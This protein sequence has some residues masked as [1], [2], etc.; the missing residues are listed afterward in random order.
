LTKVSS[1][2]SP[3]ATTSIVWAL[4]A[5]LV[6]AFAV[7]FVQRV[8]SPDMVAVA[9]S[10]GGDDPYYFF[11]VARN[12][13]QGHGITVDGT[14]WTTG[15][16]PLWAAICAMAF[17]V[18]PDRAAFA[19]IYLVSIALWLASAWLFVRIVRRAS[20][21]PLSPAIA[22][23]LVVL[24]LGETQFT[25]GYFN[26]METG[27]A[28]TCVLA[29]L[30]AFQDYLALEPRLVSLRRVLGLGVLTGLTMLARND[31]LFLCGALLAATLF[32]G[33]RR[34]PVRDVAIIVTVAS[35]M[36]APWLAY[37]QWA[38]GNPMPQSGIATS[39]GVRGYI[40]LAAVAHKIVLSIEPL[41]FL[42]MRTLADDHLAVATVPA[43][44][45]AAFLTLCWRRARPVLVPPSGW[46]LLSLAA[47][48]LCLLLFYP[49]VSA[50]GQFFERYFT[51]LKLLVFLLLALLIVRGLGRI[52]GQPVTG[53]LI[54]AVAA[55]TVGSNLYWIARDYGRPWRSHLGPEAYEIVRSPYATGTS[56]IG[57]A[58]SGRL[59]FLYPTRIV[60][61]DGKMNVEA[62][63]ALLAGRLDSYIQSANLDYIMLHDEDV[64]YFDKT[65]PAW[66]KNWRQRG[67][68]GEFEVFEKTP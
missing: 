57:M 48:T 66:R 56:R 20:R 6:G 58:E 54:V 37:C 47:A 3:S 1:G 19:I 53:V 22:A 44:A 62:L 41:G 60:N 23:L 26:G 51:P 25:R 12:I 50:A 30:A 11:T 27:L 16:Q 2:V 15:F 13:A 43:C 8:T 31:T 14:H 46:I 65:I 32:F 36:V 18:P 52:E 28:L 55:A 24:F 39:I 67:M 7:D 63:H 61:L 9:F 35:A 29:L 40:S 42:K 64:E 21:A 10:E 33:K 17:L 5:V 45:V 59:G 38:S 34:R 4:V 49:L 68:L